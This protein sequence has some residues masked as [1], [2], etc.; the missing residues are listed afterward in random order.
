MHTHEH[1]HTH[2]DSAR[3]RDAYYHTVKQIMAIIIW[4]MIREYVW[5]GRQAGRQVGRQAGRQAGR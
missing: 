5:T 2:R 4:Y 1:T 3:D